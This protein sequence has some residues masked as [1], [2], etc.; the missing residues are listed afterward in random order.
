VRR[1][2][3]TPIKT[4]ARLLFGAPH[5]R[6]LADALGNSLSTSRSW[7]AGQRR[8][9]IAVLRTVHQLLVAHVAS[10]HDAMRE[11]DLVIARREGEPRH[12]GGFLRNRAE[13]A[14]K[15]AN[16]RDGVWLR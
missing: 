14:T 8:P 13:A 12:N 9:P 4:A 10:C 15:A 2:A 5:N 1:H 16:R 7:I 6:G 3:D 11:L